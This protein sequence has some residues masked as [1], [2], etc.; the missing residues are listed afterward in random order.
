MNKQGSLLRDLRTSFGFS[1]SDLAQR[2]EV[3]R[4]TYVLI[5]KGE[6][7]LTL[8]QAELLSHIYSISVE[9]IKK[10]RTSTLPN[11][12]IIVTQLP[13]RYGLFSFGVWNQ[14]KGEEII[15]LTTPNLDRTKPVLV[16]VHSECM[17][18][19]VFHSYRCDCGE[20][21]DMALQM[22]AESGNGVFMY[23]RQ[24]G[25]GI[26]LYE[27]IKAYNLQDKGYDTH[28]ANILLGHKPDY[29]EYSWARKVLNYLDIQEIR[30]L[31][32]N[33]SKITELSRLGVTVI[34]RVP[35]II[36]SNQHN[37]R[38]FETKRQKFK[39]FFGNNEGNYFYQFSDTESPEQVEEIGRFVSGIVKDPQ[40]KI[41][42][43]T[44]A[45][46]HTLEDSQALKNLEAIFKATEHYEGF[47][48]ILHFS[49]KYSDDP[50]NDI[51]SIRK[52]M[53]F[54][55]Y[56][57]LNDVETSEYLEVIK[58]ANKFFLTD[59]PLDEESFELIENEDFV[60]EI[61]KHKSFVALDNSKGEGKKES[62]E[63]YI[64]KIDQ[65]LKVGI[66]DIAV[67]GG[68]GP[69][70]LETY[71]S[72]CNHYKINFSIDAESSLKTNNRLDVE[73][74]KQYLSELMSSKYEYHS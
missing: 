3:S 48:P 12:D 13:T 61:L 67:Y 45:N 62:K 42:V 59:I 18:G 7:E 68:F 17:T 29:R 24:E 33:P 25:R 27:K 26:G 56:L 54:V 4:P 55:K 72:L 28:E 74:V 53:P 60:K 11:E 51:A 19:D 44:S 20:Q 2:L 32:N 49:F 57:Q 47:V 36:E 70:S 39:H 9:S 1:Q 35:L 46:S 52:K 41:C 40:L 15:F 21:K 16:R 71:F 31:T 65:L 66:N 8:G 58:Y 37:R 22:I 73:K 34:D 23:L 30:I 64:K 5:E 10:G 6:R 43:G 50:K 14:K 38:Y 69:D 63:N